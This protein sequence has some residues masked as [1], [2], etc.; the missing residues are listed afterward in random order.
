MWS[1]LLVGLVALCGW[2]LWRQ[3][4]LARYMKELVDA[5]EDG[6]TYL[7]ERNTGIVRSSNFERLVRAVNSLVAQ[8]TRNTRAQHD[9]LRQVE[10]TLG[11]I[12][13]AV[14]IIDADNYV[15]LANEVLRQFLGKEQPLLGRRLET[16][17]PSA[18]F[19]DYVRSVKGG[20]KRLAE[21]IEFRKGKEV[22]WFEVNGSRLPK[23]EEDKGQL[24]L[25]VLHDVTRRKRLETMRTEFVAN[26][27]HELR[28]PVTIIKGFAETLVE[29]H[30]ILSAEDRERFLLKI[31][32]NVA[33]LHTLLEDLLILSRLEAAVEPL[34]LESQDLSDLVREIVDNFRG[35]LTDE[36]KLQVVCEPGN[37]IVNVDAMRLTQVLENLLENSVRHAKPNLIQVHLIPSA[38]GV[39][40]LVEDD[41]C[42]IPEADLPHIFERFYRV[43]KGRSRETGGTGLG[44]SIV[45]HIVLQHGGHVLAESVLHQGS[46]IGFFLPYGFRPKTQESAHAHF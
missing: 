20:E 31:Q 42:G 7:L 28:T 38:E 27:S 23:Q 9:Y 34:L 6:K 15:V 32:K 21:E 11:N 35:R 25:F 29:D 37:M 33:R 26:V 16:L 10:I 14:L 44:L 40:C 43:D 5:I 45:K 19:L 8:S 46:K 4:T 3:R 2:L 22:F 18:A 13:E 1:L 30:H 41:G 12:K 36:Q 39:R 24:T 17:V